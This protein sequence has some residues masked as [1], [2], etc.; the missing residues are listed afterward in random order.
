MTVCLK[1]IV[2]LTREDKTR[3]R[4]KRGP[5]EVINSMVKRE[6]PPQIQKK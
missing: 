1:V 2:N 6:F 4:L 3:K 5:G